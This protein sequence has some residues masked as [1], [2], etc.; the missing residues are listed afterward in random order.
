MCCRPTGTKLPVCLF[1]K[2]CNNPMRC[3]ITLW[4]NTLIIQHWCVSGKRITLCDLKFLSWQSQP[5][6]GFSLKNICLIRLWNAICAG[7]DKVEP[8]DTL[9]IL[10][11]RNHGRGEMAGAS[12]AHTCMAYTGART[13]AQSAYTRA[14]THTQTRAHMQS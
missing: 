11:L 13:R 4:S 9:N 2:Q 6:A 3:V 7:R 1:N 14:H 5:H 8:G 10:P 12:I